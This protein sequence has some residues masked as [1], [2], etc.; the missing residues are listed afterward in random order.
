MHF[1]SWKFGILNGRKKLNTADCGVFVLAMAM[2][3]AVKEII[4]H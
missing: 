2:E 1:Q 4:F 3:I